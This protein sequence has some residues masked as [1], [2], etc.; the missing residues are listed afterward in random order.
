VNQ[1]EAPAALVVEID[2]VPR[3][4]HRVRRLEH[5]VARAAVL[6]VA[7]RALRSI[8]ESFH[9]FSGSVARSAKRSS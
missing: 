6:D 7:L 5:R 2:D 3:R 8:G 4:V 1:V 9:R